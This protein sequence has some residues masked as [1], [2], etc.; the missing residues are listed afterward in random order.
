ML[1]ITKHFVLQPLK[2]IAVVAGTMA[3][4]ECIVQCDPY[5]QINWSHN[6]V[7]IENNGGKYEIVFRNGVCRLTIP[8]AFSCKNDRIYFMRNVIF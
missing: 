2:D 6:G 7:I 5:P 4:F 1:F 3:R 8:R